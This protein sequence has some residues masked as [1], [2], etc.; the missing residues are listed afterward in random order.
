MCARDRL[1]VSSR[2]ALVVAPVVLVLAGC[3][4]GGDAG[5]GGGSAGDEP[6]TPGAVAALAAERFAETAGEPTSGE[7]RSAPEGVLASLRYDSEEQHYVRVGTSTE[8]VDPQCEEL[9]E[10]YDG[11]A[12]HEGGVLAWD[13]VEPEEDPG[14]YTFMKQKGDLWVVVYY[15]GDLIEDDPRTSDLGVPV[16]A[17]V[18]LVDDPALDRTTT[19]EWVER[20]E[21]LP[22]FEAPDDRVS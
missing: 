7:G 14:V 2:L 11:C 9:L 13:E 15:A 17:A 18:A 6:I 19:Q 4:D 16:E 10:D 21:D 22:W 12:E 1:P 3:G 20:G 5:G 8:S